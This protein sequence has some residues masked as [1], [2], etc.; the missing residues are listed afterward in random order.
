MSSKL[1]YIF[2][3]G[4]ECLCERVIKAHFPPTSLAYF[5]PTTPLRAPCCSS[6]SASGAS[7]ADFFLLSVTTFSFD[8]TG[9][10]HLGLAPPE[11]W[12]GG[13]CLRL[14]METLLIGSSGEGF[15]RLEL[16]TS[17]S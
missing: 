15:F 8:T 10:L 7:L 4:H 13:S 14:V 11:S 2:K 3:T 12:L 1:R 16:Y 6:L 17:S 9:L 5:T